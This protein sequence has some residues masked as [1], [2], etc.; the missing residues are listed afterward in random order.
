[1][2]P[3]SESPPQSAET[4]VRFRFASLGPRGRAIERALRAWADHVEP[5]ANGGWH[6]SESNG[7]RLRLRARV[8]GEDWLVV[9]A[10]S[11]AADTSWWQLLRLHSGL[12]GCARLART[13]G[14]GLQVRGEISLHDGS[15]AGEGAGGCDIS[16]GDR[17]AL[18]CA[19]VSAAAHAR[20]EPLADR[21][22]DPHAVPAFDTERLV[23]LCADAGWSASRRASGQVE[24]TLDTR[25]DTYQA[26]LSLEHGS[27]FQ[28]FVPLTA[29][30]LESTESRDAIA[31][32]LLDAGA[33]LRAV[34]GLAVRRGDA[35]WAALAAAC[36]RVPAGPAAVDRALAALSVA[37][38]SV[39]REAQALQDQTLA[40]E[41][42]TL[43]DSR[44]LQ[45]G[46]PRHEPRQQEDTSCLQLP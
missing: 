34:K 22:A 26:T 39:G 2:R 28:A 7:A 38:R 43:R 27:R 32:L 18:L 12:G 45:A 46:I 23:E 14:G 5:A 44:R 11:R 4:D 19:D 20:L 29:F 30:P 36:E 15:T 6:L 35:E 3:C 37:C 21:P 24:V 13:H 1:M 17:V 42:L 9:T 8:A 25:V 10:R 33:D 31:L 41:Y 16:F 40:R